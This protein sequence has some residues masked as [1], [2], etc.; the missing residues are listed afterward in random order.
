MEAMGDVPICRVCGENA[1]KHMPGVKF[2]DLVA[3][4]DK[5]EVDAESLVT[6]LHAE[7]ADKQEM[8][9]VSVGDAMRVDQEMYMKYSGLTF[10]E[11]V[12]EFGQ[13][14]K[15]LDIKL[16]VFFTATG[17]EV[18][19]PCERDEK[20]KRKYPTVK[21]GCSNNIVVQQGPS[22]SDR[23]AI[24]PT[25]GPMMLA[26]AGSATVGAGK[27]LQAPSVQSVRLTV[28]SNEVLQEEAEKLKEAKGKKAK[29]GLK[30]G[31]TAELLAVDGEDSDEDQEALSALEAARGS[32]GTPAKWPRASPSPTAS[33]AGSRASCA[34][35]VAP[36]PRKC[37]TAAYWMHELDIDKALDGSK[38]GQPLN[39]ASLLMPKLDVTERGLLTKRMD[40][41]RDAVTMNCDNC[42][43][44]KDAELI[45]KANELAK[46]GAKPTLKLWVALAKRYTNN[47]F[48]KVEKMTEKSEIKAEL[49]DY[50][51]HICMWNGSSKRV[52]DDGCTTKPPLRLTGLV[53]QQ[54]AQVFRDCAMKSMLLKMVCDGEKS[55][56][57]VSAFIE[58]ATAVW[59]D[60]PEDAG[61]GDRC[62]LE[63]TNCSTIFTLLALLQSDS[64]FDV[65]V[66][67]S[68]AIELLQTLHVKASELHLD[69]CSVALTAAAVT[70][71]KYWNDRIEAKSKLADR[72]GKF[73]NEMKIHYLAVRKTDPD[74]TSSAAVT[75]SGAA[76]QLGVWEATL[77]AGS[78]DDLKAEVVSQS[79]QTATA[80]M[81]MIR[82]GAAV[83]DMADRLAAHKTLFKELDELDPMNDLLTR[84]SSD[85]NRAQS[86]MD[87]SA[88]HAILDKCIAEWDFSEAAATSLKDAVAAC[89]GRRLP[90]T[91]AAA[92]CDRCLGIVERFNKSM[93]TESASEFELLGVHVAGAFET[94][95]KLTA[96]EH[97]EKLTK[98]APLLQYA[99][100]TLKQINILR[101]A[102]PADGNPE[103]TDKT[104]HIESGMDAAV[105]MRTR[106][107]SAY[108][109]CNAFINEFPIIKV[110]VPLLLEFSAGVIAQSGVQARDVIKTKITDAISSL[111]EAIDKMMPLKQWEE[112][113]V[114]LKTIDELVDLYERTLKDVDTQGLEEKADAIGDLLEQ[115]KSTTAKYS[116]DTDTEVVESTGDAM[117][118]TRAIRATDAVMSFLSTPSVMKDKVA[119]QRKAMA[120]AEKLK[121]WK[122]DPKEMNDVIVA[123]YKLALKYK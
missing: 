21:I 36:N 70:T 3:E 116:L 14:P 77:G 76:R 7:D 71:C 111:G 48:E 75:L 19:Y 66:A 29:R 72:M 121:R 73:A 45:G 60:L 63:F 17:R 2:D 8:P 57:R 31:G 97:E 78:V 41:V 42:H 90:E 95:A 113:T 47:T 53:D 24:F 39:Q 28:R 104:Q 11:V 107:S 112:K 50:L 54:L 83:P 94:L 108:A 96:P 65:I 59:E 13:T 82:G 101:S 33:R 16:A 69:Q 18:V 56:L 74:G 30:S 117:I 27:D 89:D 12:K 67:D 102:Q 37:G 119:M 1:V 106:C 15:M 26:A 40:L 85:M 61:L 9:T 105:R 87:M 23:R 110:K 43:N 92:A 55:A 51:Q 80:L 22:G 109:A 114:G 88:K 5:G 44:L 20:F 118:K 32:D 52:L 123:R 93:E 122:M 35:S 62:A 25:Q 46:S 68:D 99:T 64:T 49:K 103:D 115:F 10:A 86:Q 79:Q 98:V 4:K 6:N 91:T 120:I 100:A 34:R 58:A 38:L 84:L 81:A